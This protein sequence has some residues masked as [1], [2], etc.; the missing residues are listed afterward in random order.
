MPPNSQFL[1]GGVIEKAYEINT[2]PATQ[3]DKHMNEL[4]PEM[5]L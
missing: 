4:T 3:Y 5:T 1:K 2:G